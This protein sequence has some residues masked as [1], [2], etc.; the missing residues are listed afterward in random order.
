MEKE[1]SYE[2]VFF[3]LDDT[4][5]NS[6]LMS[7]TARRNA[8]R[9]I[10]EA[11]LDV[12]EDLAFNLLMEIVKEY[13]SNYDEHFNRLIE[14]LGYQIHPKLIAAAVVAY[15]RTKISL[16]RPFPDVILTLLT[17][18]KEMKIG[19]ITDGRKV[20][21]WEKL[22]YLGV[23]HF[24]DAVII[25]EKKEHHKPSLEGFQ[26]ALD[27]LELKNPEKVIYVGNKTDT[28]ILG[29]NN[30]GFVSVLY[31]PKKNFSLE[32]LPEIQKPNHIIHRISEITKILNI[33]QKKWGI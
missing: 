30:F 9:A 33:T 24:F 11:G 3:D 14:K 5:Y 32:N 7:N 8:I 18:R 22:I 2:A 23:E 10:I 26:K 4:L 1:Q 16:L 15:H 13:G 28:D 20:K 19:I 17:L 25:N 21:Q 27:V 12:D 29:A 6:T 31:C